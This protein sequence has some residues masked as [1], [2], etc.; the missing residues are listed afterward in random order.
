[1]AL[2]LSA[3]S[4]VPDAPNPYTSFTVGGGSVAPAPLSG[5]SRV[6]PHTET[7]TSDTAGAVPPGDVPALPLSRR[8]PRT[9]ASAAPVLHWTGA[10]GGAGVS[11]L[12]QLIEGTAAAG[13]AWP[14]L[15]RGDAPTVL[16]ARTGYTQ[17]RAMQDAVTDWAG[18]N[19]PGVLLVGIVVIDDAPK[20]P[21]ELVA[22]IPVLASGATQVDVPLWRLPWVEPWRRS[23]LE[24]VQLS[25][26]PKEYRRFAADLTDLV[27][28]LRGGQHSNALNGSS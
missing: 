4:A 13:R 15:P 3:G 26:A 17:L 18:R 6:L 7:V 20:V 5:V 25:T 8:L 14:L 2:P 28:A 12:E 11:T 1:M 19:V 23:P 21:R 10:H 22:E 9:P 24:A 27:P 16:V